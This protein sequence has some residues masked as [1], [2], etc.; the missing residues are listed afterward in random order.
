MNRFQLLHPVKIQLIISHGYMG[1]NL[2]YL[3]MLLLN[4]NKSCKIPYN[5]YTK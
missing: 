1:M 4:L 5:T 2:P 3:K